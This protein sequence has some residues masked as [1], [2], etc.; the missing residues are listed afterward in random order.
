M[1]I[2]RAEIL[3][4]GEV[5]LPNGKIMGKRDYHYIYKQK[6]KVVDDRE[7]VIINK[8]AQEYRNLRAI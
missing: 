1:N 8:I 2:K 5:K 7:S 6:A 4:T 3:P